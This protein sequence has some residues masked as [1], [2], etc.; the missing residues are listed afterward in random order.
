[1]Y[2]LFVDLGRP[3]NYDLSKNQLRH[4][5]FVPLYQQQ[6]TSFNRSSSL[7]INILNT[8]CVVFVLWSLLPSRAFFFFVSFLRHSCSKKFLWR[9]KVHTVWVELL[10]HC[11]DYWSSCLVHKDL[12]YFFKMH[13]KWRHVGASQVE[14]IPQ[15]NNMYTTGLLCA[16]QILFYLTRLH[17][18]VS[19]LSNFPDL[20]IWVLMRL[21]VLRSGFE[22]SH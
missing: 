19:V 3:T 4:F 20:Q 8:F 21:F 10:Q 22:A 15:K 2:C 9:L 6:P 5:T 1:M 18:Q 16:V 17:F 13:A 12:Y 14:S 11:G 7:H